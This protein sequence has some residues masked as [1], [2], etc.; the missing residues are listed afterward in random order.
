AQPAAELIEWFIGRWNAL[1]DKPLPND[2]ATRRAEALSL[3]VGGMGKNLHP[4]DYVPWQAEFLAGN[5]LG[6]LHFDLDGDGLPAKRS[7]R[8]RVAF[9]SQMQTERRSPA[10]PPRTARSPWCA[11][12]SSAVLIRR[13]RSPAPPGSRS[14][15]PR[16]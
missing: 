12:R 5:W 15:P 4:E 13:Q 1:L 3:L 8:R 6:E 14:A 2:R 7:P 9:I 10:T 16:A 11:T